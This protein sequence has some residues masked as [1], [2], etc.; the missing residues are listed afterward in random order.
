[1]HAAC[2]I[3]RQQRA[4]VKLGLIPFSARSKSN[5][6]EVSTE[7]RQQRRYAKDLQSRPPIPHVGYDICAK[8]DEERD[9]QALRQQP[10]PDREAEKIHDAW[11]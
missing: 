8:S 3:L 5:D 10:C 9:Q 6:A 2:R 4:L 7:A 1:M 11:R